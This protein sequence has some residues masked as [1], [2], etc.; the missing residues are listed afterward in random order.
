MQYGRRVRDSTRFYDT[1]VAPAHRGRGLGRAVRLRMVRLLAE[2]GLPVREIVTTVADDN[3]PMRA[4]NKL[5]GYRPERS[6]G[7]FRLRL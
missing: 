4:V 1:V 2:Q 7:L 6:V 5:L 3:G